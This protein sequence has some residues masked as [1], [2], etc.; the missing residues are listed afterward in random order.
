MTSFWRS[1][2]HAFRGIVYAI[3]HERN[4]QIECVAAIG[5][6][7]LALFL[8]L[9]SIE[10]ALIVFLTGWV[11]AFELINTAIERM[12]DIIKPNVHPYV[13]VVKDMSAG[14]VLVSSGIAFVIGLC[15]FLPY[16]ID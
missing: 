6:I 5:V 12:L 2:R 8:P 1:I 10:L 7:G 3:H 4:F 9:S 14:A 15:V 16:L 11:L 13:R